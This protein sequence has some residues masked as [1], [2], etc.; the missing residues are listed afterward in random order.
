MMVVVSRLLAP[1]LVGM[2][3][4]C[5]LY[6]VGILVYL[7]LVIAAVGASGVQRLWY[8]ACGGCKRKSRVEMNFMEGDA[9]GLGDV[10]GRAGPT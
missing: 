1:S 10:Q 8:G 2:I 9:R 6:Q 7:G 4:C 3:A 5:L